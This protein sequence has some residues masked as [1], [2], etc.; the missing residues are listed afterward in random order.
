M[1]PQVTTVN[2]ETNSEE[3]RDMTDEELAEIEA[4]NVVES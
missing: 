1:R 2:H 4:F 3:V